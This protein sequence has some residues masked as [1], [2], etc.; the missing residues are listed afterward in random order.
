[1]MSFQE[2]SIPLWLVSFSEEDFRVPK[3]K[4]EGV[5]CL[6]LLFAILTV[7]CIALIT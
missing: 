7:Q 3:I 2:H 6:P 5:I 1:M 4:V